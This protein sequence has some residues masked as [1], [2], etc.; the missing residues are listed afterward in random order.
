MLAVLM[1]VPC[2]FICTGVANVCAQRTYG[3]DVGAAAGHGADRHFASGCAFKVMD[4]AV[5]HGLDVFFLEACGCAL[6]AGNEASLAGS[7]AVL[8][9]G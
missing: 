5:R 9:A 8:K 4:D 3:V 7:N 2:A 6:I 1:A